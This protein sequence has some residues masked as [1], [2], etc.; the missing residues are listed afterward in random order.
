MLNLK[1]FDAA[2]RETNILR[3]LNSEFIVK[4]LEY[5]DDMNNNFY[6]MVT[7]F[8]EDGTLDQLITRK[9][10]LKENISNENILLWSTQLLKGIECL[11]DNLITHRDLKPA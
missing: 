6:Y 5:Y 10:K 1:D 9:K 7:E 11:H 8:Y 3:K 4:Y 2:H